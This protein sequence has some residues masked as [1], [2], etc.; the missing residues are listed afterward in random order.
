MQEW[1][2]PT[3]RQLLGYD[4]GERISKLF[5][6]Q[7]LCRKALKLEPVKITTANLPDSFAN[8]PLGEMLKLEEK[9]NVVI[10]PAE[11]L[12]KMI[13]MKTKQTLTEKA[14]KVV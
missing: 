14:Q 3:Q 1:G 13:Q 6:P 11:S 5:T 7:P 9:E 4:K 2:K 8:T 10:T 12:L